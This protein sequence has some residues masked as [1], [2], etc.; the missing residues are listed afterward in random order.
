MSLEY[1]TPAGYPDA[2]SAL[3]A[4]LEAPMAEERRDVRRSEAG[5]LLDGVLATRA[6]RKGAYDVAIG[7][8]LAAMSVG[9]RTLTFG[10]VSIGDYA[11]ERLGLNA[12]TAQKQAKLAR[13]LRERPALREAVWSGEV[14]PCK[15][16][17]VMSLARGDAE[18]SW[19]ERAKTD[20]ARGLAAAVKSLTGK[21]ADEEEEPW[22]LL[23]IP[24]PPEARPMVEEAMKVAGKQVGHTA[25]RWDRLDA[26]FQEFLG[27]YGGV[28]GAEESDGNFL[29]WPLP[30]P[31]DSVERLEED[32]ENETKRWVYLDEVQPVVAPHVAD[33]TN[34]WRIDAELR[35]LVAERNR[36]DEELGRVASVFSSLGLWR[37]AQFA[38]FRQY[39]KER[40]GM[41]VR[42]V[43]QRIALERRLVMLPELRQAMRSGRISYE[44]ARLIAWKATGTT[45]KDWIERAAGKTC[46]SLR[47]EIEGE[48]E[49]QMWTRGW[50]EIPVPRH[51]I[52]LFADVCKAARALA[53]KPLT[54]RECFLWSVYQFLETWKCEAK[55]RNTLRNRVMKRDLGYCQAPGCSRRAAHVH[56]VEF[57]SHGGADSMENE[58]ALCAAHHLVAIHEGYMRVTG[59]APDGL[60]WEIGLR[61]PRPEDLPDDSDP[62]RTVE[63][64]QSFRSGRQ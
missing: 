28:E 32:L 26:I 24:V 1:A 33:E 48:E 22:E 20:T 25:P 60:V 55:E 49:A 54:S 35:R 42:T 30:P 14:S 3:V 13:D 23:S 47:R 11:R 37:D 21:T 4:A 18:A 59:K 16:R 9:A 27:T 2:D 8:Y 10:Y 53:R 19:V 56:H 63:P 40:L 17:I 58:I 52:E 34:P 45:V 57:R 43:Q 64:D 51:T 15:A 5:V 46:I 38:S 31:D 41:G 44:K 36:C 6:R 29:H 50:L 61:P 7:E 39:C 62:E 12:R